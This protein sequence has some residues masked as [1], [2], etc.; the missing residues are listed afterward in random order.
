MAAAVAAL[1][2]AAVGVAKA[3]DGSKSNSSRGVYGSSGSSY[4]NDIKLKTRY[5]GSSL[6]SRFSSS[7]SSSRTLQTGLR[8]MTVFSVVQFQDRYNVPGY[9]MI[10]IR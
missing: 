9:K 6:S 2:A 8:T 4:D 7:F 10:S 3:I 5:S 1:V